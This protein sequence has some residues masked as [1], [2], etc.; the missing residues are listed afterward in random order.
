[1][2]N[3]LSRCVTFLI[4]AQ[5]LFT[6]T[7]QLTA[8]TTPTATERSDVNETISSGQKTEWTPPLPPVVWGNVNRN[9]KVDFLDLITLGQNWNNASAVYGKPN[10]R[11]LIDLGQKWNKSVPSL[12]QKYSWEN[13]PLT[14]GAGIPSAKAISHYPDASKASPGD[15]VPVSIGFSVSFPDKFTWQIGKPLYPFQGLTTSTTDTT[16]LI[17]VGGLMQ[18]DPRFDPVVD[19]T[20]VAQYISSYQQEADFKSLDLSLEASYAMFNASLSSS[21]TNNQYRAGYQSKYCAKSQIDFGW[22]YVP[23]DNIQLFEDV[24]DDLQS[25]NFE[26]VTTTYGTHYV[27][28][29]HRFAEFYVDVSIETKTARDSNSIE[30]DLKA[31]YG[32]I[33][34]S[35]D[36]SAAL[37]TLHETVASGATINVTLSRRGGPNL[38]NVD[39]VDKVVLPVSFDL[40]SP[41]LDKI[42]A[43][44]EKWRLAVNAGNAATDDYYTRPLTDF[45]DSTLAMPFSKAVQLRSW[46]D[47]YVD[48]TVGYRKLET[49]LDASFVGDPADWTKLF[50]RTPY[51][52]MAAIP[53]PPNYP[54]SLFPDRLAYHQTAYPYFVN[55]LDEMTTFGRALYDGSETTF[56]RSQTRWA[57]RGTELPNVTIDADVSSFIPLPNSFNKWFPIFVVHDLDV[58]ST[59]HYSCELTKGSHARSTPVFQSEPSWRADDKTTFM[60]FLVQVDAGLDGLQDVGFANYALLVRDTLAE[61]APVV[62]FKIL[63]T[64]G[65]IDQPF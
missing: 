21:F 17:G 8:N 3:V 12:L 1:M 63:D 13:R 19:E 5:L 16:Q 24:H 2:V 31:H 28:A 42:P 55:K 50:Y 37:K 40:N 65:Y 41:L 10:F 54:P 52:Y 53:L 22:Y 57:V 29:E 56:D 51:R 38:L 33:G 6:A 11:V 35:V 7:A 46:F 48:F 62:A 34:S 58:S 4:S 60:Q 44:I 9:A 61:G 26:G 43:I 64:R 47:R 49:A 15:A 36:F 25:P 23:P 20:F 45:I 39:G 27:W 30:A 14:I 59:N 32:T 18:G